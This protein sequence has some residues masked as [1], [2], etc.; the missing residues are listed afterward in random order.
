MVCEGMLQGD[1]RRFGKK[2]QGKDS[3][4][5]LEDR[6]DWRKELKEQ[7]GIIDEIAA[8]GLDDMEGYEILGEQHLRS[9][10]GIPPSG[11]D[12]SNG[13]FQEVREMM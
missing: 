12:I 7:L 4:Y 6:M 13:F 3:I 5:K 8:A 9:V 2:K 11:R 10:K 1:D